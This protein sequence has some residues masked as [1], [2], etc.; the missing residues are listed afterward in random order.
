MIET[1]TIALP[2]KPL[3]DGIRAA[4]GHPS[5]SHSF[6]S[7]FLWQQD[8]GLSVR[9]EKEAFLVRCTSRG[10][11]CWYFPCGDREQA[12]SWIRELLLE[13]EP[14]RLVYLRE[15]DAAF[16]SERFPDS[17]EIVPAD[18]DSEYLYDRQAYLRMEGEG[19]RRIRRGV[20]KLLAENEVR[21]EPWTADN[22]ADMETVLQMWHARHPG[23]DGLMDLGTS[24]L[25][26]EHG[27]EL[28][29]Q[30]VIVYLD[31]APAAM[32]AGF[33][34]NETSFDIAFSKSGVRVTGLQD[35]TRQ[36]LARLLPER[37]TILNGEDDL[38]IPG[39]RKVKRLMRPIGQIQMCEAR[40][41]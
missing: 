38:G 20:K 5:E 23:E 22:T 36:A 32:C 21:E 40:K 7:L 26:L 35:Y 1:E 34:L 19:Y 39:I 29:F 15:E 14:L 13:E 41:K 3:I 18:S 11:N 30:G 33:P 31:G 27:R 10:E 37:Y 25:L 16:L 4:S 24:R 17:F 28:D 12:E 9:L 6:A 8:M 2:V